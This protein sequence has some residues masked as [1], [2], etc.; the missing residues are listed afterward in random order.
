MTSHTCS[1]VSGSEYCTSAW[2]PCPF[3]KVAIFWTRPKALNTRCSVSQR[4]SH[5][6]LHQERVKSLH[7]EFAQLRPH[8]NDLTAPGG[9][10]RLGRLKKQHAAGCRGPLNRHSILKG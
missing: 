10:K 7:A 6:G 3:S 5:I 2:K 9:L 4:H 1:A 8:R